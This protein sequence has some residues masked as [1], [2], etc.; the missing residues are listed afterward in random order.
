MC[1]SQHKR[2]GLQ[3]K[4]YV[5]VS[6]FCSAV[7]AFEGYKSV[8]F[9]SRLGTIPRNAGETGDSR[10]VTSKQERS[11]CFSCEEEENCADKN[12]NGISQY[13]E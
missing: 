2:H 1:H 10:D 12:M 8:I 3:E 4:Y 11:S 13:S 7:K 9:H 5:P 6:V